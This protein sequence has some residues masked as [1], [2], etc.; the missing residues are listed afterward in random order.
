MRIFGR[1]NKYTIGIINLFPEIFYSNIIIFIWIEM[2]QC[3]KPIK[4]YYFKIIFKKF[5]NG[6]Y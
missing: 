1:A 5:C 4:K 3:S 2:R 6:I